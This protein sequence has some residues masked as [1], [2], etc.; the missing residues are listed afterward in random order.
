MKLFLAPHNDDETLFGAYTILRHQPWVIVVLR[1]F[2]EASWIDGPNYHTR[3]KET[4]LALQTLGNNGGAYEQWS[5]RDSNPP[6]N[7]IFDELLAYEDDGEIEHV[8]APAVQVG[9]H[10]HHNALGEIASVVFPT[11]RVTYY[12]T[13]T[14]AG[15]KS[16]DGELVDG[17]WVGQAEEEGS[18]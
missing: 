13:Y 17:T 4:R 18:R 3:E 9:G 2:V 12:L 8:W 14:H 1:S 15:G 5:Y 16:T 11:D 7:D 10:Y 6:W